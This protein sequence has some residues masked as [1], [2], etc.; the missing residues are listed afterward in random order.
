MPLLAP[1][2]VLTA[3]LVLVLPLL[4]ILKVMDRRDDAYFEGQLRPEYRRELARMR[5]ERRQRLGL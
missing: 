2:L 3:P 5:A 4:V 1:L